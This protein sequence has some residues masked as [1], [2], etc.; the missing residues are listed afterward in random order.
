MIFGCWN[1]QSYEHFRVYRQ[2]PFLQC[3]ELALNNYPL[4][5]PLPLC[6]T[7]PKFLFYLPLVCSIKLPTFSAL[8]NILLCHTNSVRSELL[9]N[10][11]LPFNTKKLEWVHAGTVGYGRI[12]VDDSSECSVLFQKQHHCSM[13]PCL[14]NNL[15]FFSLCR[16]CT[17]VIKML[18]NSTP[19]LHG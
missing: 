18:G 8:I 5:S 19:N 13:W 11:I 7:P 16:C 17:L 9:S 12:V 3:S 2:T 10:L 14:Y 1:V 6:S 4:P 15:F